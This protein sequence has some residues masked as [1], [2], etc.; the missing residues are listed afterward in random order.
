[1]TKSKALAKILESYTEEELRDAKDEPDTRTWTAT[2]HTLHSG[3]DDAASTT[4]RHVK[5]AFHT[6]GHGRHPAEA[7]ANARR[8]FRQDETR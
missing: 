1:M 8:I 2:V 3:E 6:A 4:R 7:L 5:R